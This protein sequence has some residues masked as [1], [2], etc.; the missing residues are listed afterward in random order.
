MGIW[1]IPGLQVHG[2]PRLAYG[3][4]TKGNQADAK[5]RSGRLTPG[6][7]VHQPPRL[8]SACQCD[9]DRDLADTRPASAWLPK[10]G[11]GLWM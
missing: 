9:A 3:G 11:N 2:S 4:D 5:L 7:Q 1:L 10:T 8:V 6:L